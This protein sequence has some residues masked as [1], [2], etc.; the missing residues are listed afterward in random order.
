MGRVMSAQ[1]WTCDARGV[2]DP[3]GYCL[4]ALA[5]VGVLAD[6]A[7][8][9]GALRERE[10]AGSTYVG[11]GTALPHIIGT[12]ACAP[13]LLA[14]SCDP[15]PWGDAAVSLLIFLVAPDAED[16]A[17]SHIGD[18]MHRAAVIGLDAPTDQRAREDILRLLADRGAQTI[19]GRKG[20][21]V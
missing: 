11:R 20:P 5:G 6:V 10:A 17:D 16:L 4:A 3:V 1:L 15:L 12:A 21:W 18:L 19:E 2:A 7:G 8:A 14:A 9:A 13:A